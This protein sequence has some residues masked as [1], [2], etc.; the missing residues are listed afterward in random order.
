M[1]IKNF[2]N[3]SYSNLKTLLQANIVKLCDFWTWATQLIIF[4]SGF[5]YL[6]NL[7][8]DIKKVDNN[9]LIPRALEK[10]FK[11]DPSYL[12]RLKIVSEDLK[13]HFLLI[14]YLENLWHLRPYV[15]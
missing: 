5:I 7:Y 8:M 3:N 9:R 13:A 4:G 10:L 15:Q 14:N 1:V 11:N 6:C 2:Q 12:C